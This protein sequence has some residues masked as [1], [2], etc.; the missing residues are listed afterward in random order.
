MPR[1]EK[2]MEFNGGGFSDFCRYRAMRI[3]EAFG[4]GS[5]EHPCSLAWFSHI[6]TCD[7]LPSEANYCHYWA[8][9]GWRLPTQTAPISSCPT[10]LVTDP[11]GQIKAMLLK[12]NFNPV[13]VSHAIKTWD[14]TQRL[15]NVGVKT[16]TTVN[17]QS[18]K[19]SFDISYSIIKDN[20]WITKRYKI[21]E[22]RSFRPQRA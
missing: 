18:I 3:T 2:V 10:L 15:H 11:T 14:N 19:K 17:Y 21:T 7:V 5:E 16:V 9:Y 20:L 4:T 8:Q 1:E 13:V 12:V 6:A 22:F